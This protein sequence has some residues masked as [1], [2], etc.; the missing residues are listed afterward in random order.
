VN[1]ICLFVLLTF[2]MSSSAFAQWEL[3]NGESTINYVSIKKS[4]IGE[5]NGFKKITGSIGDSGTVSLNIDLGSVETNIP[6]RNDR[7]KSMLFEVAKF[8]EATISG[9][10]DVSRLSKLGVGDTYTDSVRLKL[11]LHGV[12]HDFATDMQIT[13]LTDNRLLVNSVKPV[14]INAENYNLAEG[15]EQLRTVANLPSIST[16]VPV[17]FNL[18][19]RQ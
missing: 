2:F 14:I 19:F 13:R 15:V 1:K 11:S 7:M 6:I 16:A 12:S 5:V 10:V 9:S 4:S 8:S 3:V 17:T 18:M